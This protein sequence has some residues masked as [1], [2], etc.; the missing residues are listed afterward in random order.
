MATKTSKKANATKRTAAMTST[1]KRKPT[2]AATAS[3]SA[4]QMNKGAVGASKPPKTVAR[5]A[6]GNK[7]GGKRGC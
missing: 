1:P 5:P 2:T 7:A 4:R 6:G 3:R